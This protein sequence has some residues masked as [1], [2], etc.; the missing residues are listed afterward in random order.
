MI[1]IIERVTEEVKKDEAYRSHMY[2]DSKK[3]LTI[4]YGLN[5]DDGIS[6]PLA[7]KIVEWILQERLQSLKKLFPFLE[8]LTPARQEVLLNMSY[9]L[10]Y[11]QVPQIHRH[12]KGTPRRRRRRRLPTNERFCLV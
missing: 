10:G 6:E 1:P 11:P 2:P 12:D 4:G 8:T 9:N 3:V 5:L 7:A